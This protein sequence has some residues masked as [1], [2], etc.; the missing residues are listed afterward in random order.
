MIV[1]TIRFGAFR[2]A[3]DYR[4][5]YGAFVFLLIV[6]VHVIDQVKALLYRIDVK[7]F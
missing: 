1:F 5:S 6:I 4:L 7:I 2:Q 3:R